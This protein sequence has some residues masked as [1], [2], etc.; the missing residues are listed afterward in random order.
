MAK[1]KDDDFSCEMATN[2]KN[3]FWR[4]DDTHT[5]PNGAGGNT[6]PVN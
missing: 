3:S 4:V 2:G 5:H 1:E 6:G